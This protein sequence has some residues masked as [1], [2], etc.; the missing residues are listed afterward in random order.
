MSVDVELDK[1]DFGLAKQKARLED[2]APPNAFLILVSH[3]LVEF[4][5]PVNV[6]PLHAYSHLIRQVSAIGTLQTDHFVLVLQR[7]A[8]KHIATRHSF[9]L[10][11]SHKG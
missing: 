8:I 9:H 2:S 3:E 10:I 7:Q 4:V 11:S 1:L 5:L 6:L